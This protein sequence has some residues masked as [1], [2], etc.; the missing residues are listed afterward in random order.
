MFT[1]LYIYRE[2]LDIDLENPYSTY[3]PPSNNLNT[4]N[5]EFKAGKALY[6]LLVFLALC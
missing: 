4:F 3:I 5:S 6:F 2:E 1:S